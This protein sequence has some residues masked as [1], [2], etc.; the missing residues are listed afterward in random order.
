MAISETIELLQDLVRIPSVSPSLAPDEG[1]GEGAIATFA[2]EWL[3][4]RGVEAWV[5]DVAAG[6]SNAVGRVAGAPGP[7]LILYAHLDTVQ[8]T[9]MTIVGMPAASKR[10]A[11]IQPHDPTS[12]TGP[13]R[14]DTSA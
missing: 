4:L 9:N 5:D 8:T 10:A 14:T 11:S 6:R 12:D 2:V 1:T 13:S 3:K 7:T